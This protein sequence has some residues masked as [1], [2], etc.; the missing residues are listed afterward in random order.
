MK[1]WLSLN[2]SNNR[3][4]PSLP[5]SLTIVQNLMNSY[6]KERNC[7]S[8]RIPVFGLNLFDIISDQLI[9]T[10]K[11]YNQSIDEN[12]ISSKVKQISSE[13]SNQFICLT[14]KSN[15]INNKSE[16]L[17]KSVVPYTQSA[18]NCSQFRQLEPRVGNML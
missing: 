2:E 18:S 10:S 6:E 13:I 14:P 16:D 11:R 7:L 17:D 4:I 5:S 12:M 8:E 15:I 9:Q 3:L 1:N